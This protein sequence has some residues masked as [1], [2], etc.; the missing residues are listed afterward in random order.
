MPSAVAQAQSECP[1]PATV[2]EAPAPGI[3]AG[4]VEANPTPANLMSFALEARNYWKGLSLNELA[5]ATCVF[6]LEGGL[7]FRFHLRRYPECS[8]Y[9]VAS[10]QQYGLFRTATP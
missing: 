7:E 10:S 1:R 9:R 2:A 4:E 5:Y 3:T 6:K 8:W